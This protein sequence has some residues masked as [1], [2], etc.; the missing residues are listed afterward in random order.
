VVFPA[1]GWEIIAN[2]RLRATS[3]DKTDIL[4]SVEERWR[5]VSHRETV[6]SSI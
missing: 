6:R 5:V 4:F 1:S 2:V 3:A